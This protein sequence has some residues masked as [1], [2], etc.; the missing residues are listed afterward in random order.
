MKTHI[1]FPLLYALSFL[2]VSAA[3]SSAHLHPFYPYSVS[4]SL[5]TAFITYNLNQ[6]TI[7]PDTVRGGIHDDSQLGSYNI[8]VKITASKQW[9]T[10]TAINGAAVQDGSTI[11]I[12]QGQTLPVEVVFIPYADGPDTESYCL[13]LE[14]SPTYILAHQCITLAVTNTQSAVSTD[15]PTAN[16]IIE[17]N[18]AGNYIFVRGLSDLQ[19]GYRYEIFSIGGAEVGHGM[20]PADARINLQDLPSGA[21]RLLVF[22]GKRTFSNMAFTVLH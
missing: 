11:T 8:T 4:F 2:M 21:Y 7:T 16:V 13:T 22:D 17:P 14:M 6:K 19:F 20:L 12:T 10:R 3:S 9:I 18:P 5:D 1:A 15:L